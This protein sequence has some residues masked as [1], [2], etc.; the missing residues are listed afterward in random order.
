MT[1]FVTRSVATILLSALSVCP[2]LAQT[3]TLSADE[4]ELLAYRLTEATVQKMLNVFRDLAA[5]MP[6]DPLDKE[7]QTIRARMKV[8][9]A[10]EEL[11]DAESEEMDK[12]S[13]R[14][15]EIRETQREKEDKDGN[16]NNDQTIS[17]MERS[18][19]KHPQMMAA[20]QRQGLGARDYAKFWLAM[21]Q[22]G[23]V[24]AMS[25]EKVDYAKLPPG[26]NVENVKFVEQHKEMLEQFQKI[27][28]KVGKDKL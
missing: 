1:R 17:D 20:L 14:E 22:A 27:T 28:D 7:L 6:V 10:K 21:L 24:V 12:L 4:K 11:T 2:S 9:S 25:G 18:V 26:I 19:K 23:L 13:T 16:D 3:Q 8:L 15:E 5:T